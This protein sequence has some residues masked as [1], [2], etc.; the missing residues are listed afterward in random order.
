M[1]TANQMYDC[2]LLEG[3]LLCTLGL[4]GVQRPGHTSTLVFLLV[5]DGGGRAEGGVQ[6][7]GVLCW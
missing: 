2:P 4:V 6:R 3:Q 5:A 7:N 1:F